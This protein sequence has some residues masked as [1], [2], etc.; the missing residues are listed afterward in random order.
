MPGGGTTR[1]PS[2]ARHLA[3]VAVVAL[4][5]A[6][7]AR[8]A[9]FPVTV[10]V[11]SVL[12]ISV[13]DAWSRPPD[14]YARIWI[15]GAALWTPRV[16]DSNGFTSPSGWTFTRNVSRPARRGGF[17][18]VRLELFDWDTN[19]WFSDTQVDID[20][21]P[22]GDPLFGCGSGFP[23]DSFG[24]DVD[25]NLFDGSWTPAV[26]GGDASGTVAQMAC[27][28]GAGGNVAN[29]CFTITVGPPT[30][31][32]LT[33][34]KTSDSDRGVCA[35]GDCSL[36]EAISRADSGDTVALPASA[37]PYLLL[38][39]ESDGHL[40]IHDPRCPPDDPQCPAD[41]YLLY[42]RGPAS[43]TAVIRQT[44]PIFRVFDVHR[45]AKLVMS[46]VTVTGGNADDTST[47][48]PS[49]IHGGGIHNHGTIE[50]THVTLT[51]NRATD[52]SESVGGGG[53]IYNATNAT[54]RLTNVTIAGNSSASNANGIPLG[55]GIAGPG[56]FTL[57]NTVI[58]NNTVE[59]TASF[60]NCGLGGRIGT[61]MNIVDDGGNLQ[62][63]GSDC[64]RWA[65]FQSP[66]GGGKFTFWWPFIRAAGTNP[67][68]PLDARSVYPPAG[69]AVEGGAAGCGP[70]DQVGGLAPADGN[71]DGTAACDVGAVEHQP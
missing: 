60:S 12:N 23:G 19:E 16:D 25:L 21:A 20:P 2:R 46:R 43:G 10:T 65:T 11:N 68:S 38:G 61:P 4:V 57:R 55:G 37:A 49:H 64:G 42:V 53:G 47:A 28:S 58:A 17:V 67:L 24:I 35:P 18:P 41:T 36:R 26:P 52:P 1:R 51:G 31:D 70:T 30:S 34:S 62:F 5:Y 45:R 59:G 13:G 48:F 22:C 63:P 40:A 29:I 39:P 6:V 15:D 69:E 14:F 27:T 56:A 33:V 8:A 71:G 7:E 32:T 3:L 44:A 9:S 66:R 50:L 54:A